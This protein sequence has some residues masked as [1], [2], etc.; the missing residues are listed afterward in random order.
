MIWL[1]LNP[2][3]VHVGRGVANLVVDDVAVVQDA[4]RELAQFG[5]VPVQRYLG[6]RSREHLG[7]LPADRDDPGGGIAEL[8]SP[9]ARGAPEEHRLAQITQ[10]LRPALRHR[11]LAAVDH[12]AAQN[13]HVL[14]GGEDAKPHQVID[15]IL[16]C[17]VEHRG[18]L[19]ADA[20]QHPGHAGRQHEARSLVGVE[21]R[22]TRL[23]V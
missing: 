17:V 22:Q 1:T 3:L 10:F 5:V 2:T 9:E 16:L 18:G 8:G 12:P 6:A 13:R 14:G 23:G 19:V 21:Q 20:V 15:D 4:G 11:R 7:Q